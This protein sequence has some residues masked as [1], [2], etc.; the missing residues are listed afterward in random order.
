MNGDCQPLPKEVFPAE[1][2]FYEGNG[3]WIEKCAVCGLYHQSLDKIRPRCTGC[4]KDARNKGMM[5]QCVRLK[6]GQHTWI[7]I[8]IEK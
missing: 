3:Y 8:F 2:G 1:R 5:R 6:Q 4:G 7:D